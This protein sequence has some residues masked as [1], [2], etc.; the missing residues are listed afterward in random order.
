MTGKA[1][2]W[3]GLNFAALQMLMV[4]VRWNGRP[5]VEMGAGGE[6]TVLISGDNPAGI[7]QA[8]KPGYLVTRDGDQ[9]RLMDEHGYSI[10]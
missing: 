1:V 7:Y 3:D 6:V 8:I 10:A 2:E 4:G 5:G 9:V